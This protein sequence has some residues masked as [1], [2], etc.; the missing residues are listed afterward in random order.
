MT[1]MRIAI[2]GASGLIGTRLASAFQVEGHEVLKLVRRTPVHPDEVY[3]NPAAG[4]IDRRRLEELDVVIHLAGK[5]LDQK[6]WNPRIKQEIWASRVDGT[7]LISKTLAALENPPRL[8]VSASA[9]DYYEFIATP[10]G[11]S[12]GRPG[13]GFVSEMCQ[14]WEKA[15]ESAR[16][17]G[18]RV[19]T[20]RIPSVLGGHGHAIDAVLLPLCKRGLGPVFGSGEQLVCYIS[21]DDLVRAIHHIIDDEQLSGPVNVIAP[22]PVTFKTLVRTLSRIL[23][24]RSYVRIP[25]FVLR[26]LMGEVAGEF[27]EGD[28]NLRP[29]R[30][31]A[32]GFRFLYPDIEGA[33][34]HELGACA[35][36]ATN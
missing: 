33:L 6:R 23:G 29:E 31:E 21:C 22:A 1:T 12:D 2:T 28:A 4:E 36:T 32:S 17:A 19:V 35:A 14:A 8:L 24:R 16:T 5:P 9:T 34:R 18:I 25:G 10:I 20:I 7:T 15:T 27:L 13:T 11:E 3:W 30:L 26:L